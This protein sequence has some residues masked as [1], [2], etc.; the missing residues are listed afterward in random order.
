MLPLGSQV[1]RSAELWTIVFTVGLF[2]FLAFGARPLLRALGWLFT[3]LGGPG[4]E[5]IDL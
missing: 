5:G 2:L 1:V 4:A 3:L